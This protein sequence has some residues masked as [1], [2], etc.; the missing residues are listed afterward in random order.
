M[1][2][3]LGQHF[4]TNPAVAKKIAASLE[5]ETGDTIIE[6]GPGHGELTEEIVASSEKR[7]A[8]IIL[9]ERDV[10]LVAGLREKYKTNTRIEIHE[11]DV[12]EVL[13]ALATRYSLLATRYSLTGNLPYYL[14]GFL[15]RT[16]G[17]LEHKPARSVFMIQKEVAERIVARPPRMNRLFFLSL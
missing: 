15:L 9:I 4:L 13:P 6:I 12:L 3:K 7:E 1:R 2:Q 5:V 14:T 11:G 16:I 10:E 8:K 17:E